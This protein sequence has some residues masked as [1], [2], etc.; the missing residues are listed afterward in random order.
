MSGHDNIVNYYEYFQENEK[1]YLVMEFLDGKNLSEL[2]EEKGKLQYPLAF[3]CI[4][5]IG[6]ALIYVHDNGLVHRDVQP[7][8]IMIVKNKVKT[9]A[10]LI[11]FGIGK[12]PLLETNV[13]PSIKNFA[14]YEQKDG[15]FDQKLDVYA[16]AAN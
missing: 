8:N 14:H 15:I 9:R 1:H 16:L 12:N 10:V 13:H 5:Q 6:L 4:Y 2:L 11:D 3:D 7:K